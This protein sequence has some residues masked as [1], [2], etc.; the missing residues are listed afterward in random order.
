MDISTFIQGLADGLPFVTEIRCEEVFPGQ[1]RVECAGVDG[2]R[3]TEYFSL[4]VISRGGS[5]LY[6]AT[7]LAICR[8]VSDQRAEEWEKQKASG[9]CVALFAY[10]QFAR[11]ASLPVPPPPSYDVAFPV[12]LRPMMDTPQIV[13]AFVPLT[14]RIRFSLRRYDPLTRV[15][16]Y[17]V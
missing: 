4:E 8:A 15:A 2:F 3:Y 1:L 6:E 14:D 17:G 5:W 13:S 16:L 7:R 11:Q 10:G 12:R 9:H